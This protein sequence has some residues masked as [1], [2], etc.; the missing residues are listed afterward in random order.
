MPTG[1]VNDDSNALNTNVL[2]ATAG[3]WS[4]RPRGAQPGWFTVGPTPP[5][6]RT[7]SRTHV[8]ALKDSPTYGKELGDMTIAYSPD[9]IANAFPE[10]PPPR[11]RSRVPHPARRQS[12]ISPTT[13]TTPCRW[14]PTA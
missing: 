9:V 1:M 5:S 8:D 4:C 7:A 6:R 14:T 2:T 3:A 13:R 12:S 11:I 10:F